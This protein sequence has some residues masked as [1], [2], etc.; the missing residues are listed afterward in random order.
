MVRSVMGL[1]LSRSEAFDAAACSIGIFRLESTAAAIARI[2]VDAGGPAP[3][4]AAKSPSGAALAGCG[5][6]LG[7]VADHDDE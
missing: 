3:L 6:S 7:N 2:R 1:P 4:L 5:G